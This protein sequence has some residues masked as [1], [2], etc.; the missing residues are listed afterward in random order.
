M[1][2]IS[3]K[4]QFI[5]KSELIHGIG[6]YGYNEVVY[7][8]RQIKVKI[9]CKEHGIFEQTPC[10][11]IAKH[12][13]KKCA[14]S[15]K[16]ER[17]KLTTEKFIER[18][19]QVHGTYYDYSL[20]N[21]K[22]STNKIDIICKY[23]NSFLQTPNNHLAGQGCSDCGDKS[24][25]KER[26]HTKQQFIEKARETH[27]NIYDYS[28]VE[29]NNNK[30]KVDIFCKTH[31]I[32]FSQRPDS[33]LQGKGCNK[34]ADKVKGWSHTNWK[35]AGEKSK[36][37]D[38]FKVYIIKC[39]NKDEEFYKIGKTYQTIKKRFS[40]TEAMPYNWKTIKIYKGEAIEMSKLEREL[41]KYNKKLEYNPKIIFAGMYECFSKIT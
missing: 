27:G 38:S 8:G 20:V 26:T 16:A 5:N 35:V 12:G 30:D 23:H 7:K 6:V 4:E 9:I 29:Y 22:S 13:C 11:H 34:C 2:K 31:E 18:A 39:W 37:F 14:N 3:T 32:I 10:N 36:N 40:G 1:P 25:N 28:L 33:H 21:Y 24:K 17:R 41:Q 15:T 19:K